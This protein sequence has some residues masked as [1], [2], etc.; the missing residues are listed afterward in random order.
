MVKATR[1]NFTD[2]PMYLKDDRWHGPPGAIVSFK[3]GGLVFCCPA[4][5]ELGSPKDDAHWQAIKGNYTDV[6][7][8]TLMPSIAKS[9]CGWHGYLVD[10]V[11][12]L[13]AP[14]VTG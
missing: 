6:T 3:N 1:I 9:C 2:P 8:L 14:R 4:C 11:F 12:Q 5:G 13:E 10:G 7:T